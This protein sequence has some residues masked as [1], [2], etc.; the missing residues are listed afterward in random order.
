MVKD[1][2]RTYSNCTEPTNHLDIE[3]VD[4][5]GEALNEFTGGLI[6]VSHDARLIREL[7][8]EVMD[9]YYAAYN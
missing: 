4:A 8:C 9:C 2:P 7:N 3:S 6:L 1:Y 5:L